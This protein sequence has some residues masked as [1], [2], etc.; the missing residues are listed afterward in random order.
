MR[1]RMIQLLCVCLILPVLST[2]T[3]LADIQLKYGNIQLNG[4]YDIFSQLFVRDVTLAY[5]LTAPQITFSLTANS[6]TGTPNLQSIANGTVDFS[7]ISLSPL[8][9]NY[10]ALIAQ[11]LRAVPLMAGAVVPCYRLDALGS[12]A[13]P[14][15]FSLPVLAAI[16]VGNITNWSDQRL[17]SLNPNLS[18]P[19]QNI[20]IVIGATSRA[21]EE[22]I[23]TAL[24]AAVPAFAA[25]YTPSRLMNW[26][27]ANY[28]AYNRCAGSRCTISTV[29]TIDGSLGFAGLANLITNKV[30]FGNLV[31]AANNVVVPSSLSVGFTFAELAPDS[32]V[33]IYAG[34]LLTALV[35]PT[36][37]RAWPMIQLTWLVTRSSITNVTDV[38]CERRA[39]VT[40]FLLF[41]LQS[42]QTAQIQSDRQY[43]PLPVIGTISSTNV[44][45]LFR[46]L[47]C[48]AITSYSYA[49]SLQLPYSANI[50]EAYV[51]SGYDHF[52]FLFDFL[53][54]YRTSVE[55]LNG[56]QVNFTFNGQPTSS[57]SYEKMKAGQVDMAFILMDDLNS[58]QKDEVASYRSSNQFVFLP[59]FAM[60]IVPLY[61]RTL[62]QN[63]TLPPSLTLDPTTAL[64]MLSR[65]LTTWSTP[66]IATLNPQLEPLLGNIP[67]R[68][69]WSCPGKG[70]PGTSSYELLKMSSRF[71]ASIANFVATR[72]SGFIPCNSTFFNRDVLLAPVP[73]GAFPS[74]TEDGQSVL[75]GLS[76]GAFTAVWMSPFTINA[77]NVGIVNM[78]FPGQTTPVSASTASYA[79]CYDS[80][81]PV[82]STADFTKS[83]SMLCYSFSRAM[84]AMI[85]A[86]YIDNDGDKCSNIEP[87][88]RT[89]MWL[90]Q[91]PELSDAF[92]TEGVA[93]TLSNPTVTAAIVNALENVRCIDPVTGDSDTVLGSISIIWSTGSAT[94]AAAWTISGIGL[95]IVFVCLVMLLLFRSHS[96]LRASDPTLLALT[97]LGC[98]LLYV[99]VIL[100]VL[101]ITDSSCAALSWTTHVGF[102]LMLAVPAVRTYRVYRIFGGKNLAVVKISSRR[103]L[104]MIS[105]LL[106]IE[107][108]MLTV[109]Q[110]VGPLQPIS[111]S[112]NENDRSHIYTQCSFKSGPA[113]VILS[114]QIAIKGLL[115]GGSAIMAFSTRRVI[116]SIN[117]SSRIAWSIYNVIGSILIMLIIKQATSAKGDH[118]LVLNYLLLFWIASISLVLN[119]GSRLAALTSSLSNKNAVNPIDSTRDEP[120]GREF[121]LL[122]HEALG[123]STTVMQYLQAMEEQ[124]SQASARFAMIKSGDH[125]NREWM[126]KPSIVHHPDKHNNQS[127]SSR[128]SPAQSV[129][130]VEMV[131][132]GT[133][134][135]RL[136]NGTIVPN[137][138]PNPNPALL[139]ERRSSLSVQQKHTLATPQQTT[140]VS[141]A[142]QTSRTL[143][144]HS[145]MASTTKVTPALKAAAVRGAASFNMKAS[146]ADITESAENDALAGTA[147]SELIG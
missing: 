22:V 130:E 72:S 131:G 117:E 65:N 104:I 40:S 38:A 39:V 13:L 75:V 6:D 86:S 127:N 44:V 82:D 55:T 106:V 76:Q 119:L 91:A 100:L 107:F 23:S 63:I 46:R 92:E 16:F 116:D 24:A 93:R 68:A 141:S 37:A 62:T 125:S 57:L 110:I 105:G 133:K 64:N 2:V 54:A 122:Q 9:H 61:S 20:T 67:V 83:T 136:S 126:K 114:V 34:K 144:Q 69:I 88:L 56:N 96:A 137:P 79:E 60:G 48:N 77:P 51:V 120:K 3:T 115:L 132:S 134:R 108:V 81:N 102:M 1:R 123:D 94:K 99:S 25:Q 28:S 14:V 26:P 121:S 11:G 113:V 15:I 47:T 103:M 90:T 59:L 49:T 138:N 112:I 7:M 19:N 31:N 21:E 142:P 43:S 84:Y 80:F 50:V 145:R 12:P 111:E 29:T 53:F 58:T 10:T 78:L 85:P 140:L 74:S 30:S 36:G 45:S 27:L 124:L 5:T 143:P 32:I 146:D 97:S 71:D 8:V 35:N 52:E 118:V 95:A 129:R 41:L 18:M 128:S 42:S 139:P 33:T 87:L 70:S 89:L 98:A 17:R 73:S 109:A 147:K 135:P 101:P 4:T 66:A